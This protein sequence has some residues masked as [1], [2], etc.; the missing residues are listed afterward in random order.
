MDMI[1][2]LAKE[3]GIA[4][5]Q[6]ESAVRLID[7]GNTIP[8]I[9]RYRK[10]VTG[11]LDDTVLRALD[12]RLNYLRSLQ[13][14]RE[15]VAALIENSGKLDE[16]QMRQM[17]E[18]L[19]KA[20]QLSEIEDLYRPYKQ[21]KRTRA[22]IAKEKGLEPLAQMI[23]EQNCSEQ[24]LQSKVSEYVGEGKAETAQEALDGA[25]DIIA[26]QISDSAEIRS[27]LRKYLQKN[28]VILTTKGTKENEV[29]SMYYEYSESI[30]K[31]APHRILAINRGEKEEALR[32]TL[33]AE[34][35][36]CFAMME[37]RVIRHNSP[38][39]QRLS[40]ICEDSYK[41]LIFPSLERE[42]RAEL[43]EKADAQAIGVFSEN[44]KNLLMQPPMKGSVTMGFDP[45]YRTGC[46]IAVVDRTGKVLDTTVVYPTPPQSKT[47]QAK[48]VLTELIKKHG[49][50]VIAIGNGT[51]S[52]ESEIFVAELLGELNGKRTNK[53]SYMVVSEAGA[54]VYSASE[55]GAR[56]FPQ[57]DVSLRSAVSIARRLQDPLAE[58]VKI[59]PKAIGVG[60]YQ[61]DMPAKEMDSALGGVVEDCVNKV[62]V[63]LNTAS[64]SLLSYVAGI[65]RT[66]AKNIVDYREEN[67]SFAERKE[68][69]KVPKLG[70]KAFEQC[71]GF[72]RISEGENPLDRTAVH[73]ESY[74]PAKKLL[75]LCGYTMQDILDKKVTS[76]P[77][78]VQELGGTALAAQRIGIGEPTL[79]DM[80]EELIKPGRDPR[81]ELP[82]P[83]LRTDVME[84]KDLKPE[85]VLTGT[86]RNVTDFGAFVDIAV[87]EDG[88]V[89]ISQICDR[90]I[91]HPSEI[92]KVGDIVKVKVLEVD[93][94]RKRIS[95][96]MKG[97]S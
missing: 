55:L 49:V 87:H 71:A 72:L 2:I 31:I 88:L 17:R 51:A 23:W 89:H 96:T 6:A 63:D 10:E 83:L 94:N 16:K 76:L 68:L 62:G 36:P 4:E 48:R 24:Q 11:G 12:E 44:L 93:L 66:V 79:K 59:D 90:Y 75:T 35:Q 82:K 42:L 40:E 80:I 45:A 97:I 65:N 50:E 30:Q 70:K 27:D 67:G 86:V 73:P 18:Q 39:T 95:L 92:L 25:G 14:R 91:K 21:K 34:P 54:S 85:M 41:R 61:H 20:Q 77:Q 19:D 15:E 52:K 26:E 84:L 5:Q 57:F 53:I 64:Q 7:E 58:L 81:D 78:R 1:Q 29:Y 32:V 69:M 37:R 46:K 60:Q 22:S 28:A 38:L 33:S 9:A 56:E 8:F 3:L 74:E 13:K 43:T 47:E